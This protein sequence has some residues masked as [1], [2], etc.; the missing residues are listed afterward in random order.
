MIQRIPMKRFPPHCA[1][2]LL[3]LLGLVQGR[4]QEVESVVLTVSNADSTREGRIITFPV[5]LKSNGDVAGITFNLKYNQDF[6][7]RPLFEWSS[8]FG[9]SINSVNTDTPGKMAFTFAFP[10]LTVP[11]GDQLVGNLT[12]RVRSMPFGM[13]TLI[14]PELIE[15]SDAL[16]DP[17]AGDHEAKLGVA[18]ID[19]RRV[20]GD[21]NGN[22]Y[23]DVGDATLIQ[24]LVA[25]LDSVRSWDIGL[26]D[27]NK[28]GGLDSGDV[29]KVLRVVV[30]VD[31]QPEGNRRLA[32]M[33]G[34]DDDSDEKVV[35]SIVKMN[36]GV[37]TVQVA[38][39]DMTTNVSG[40]S[41]ELQFSN[42]V[43]RLKKGSTSSAGGGEFSFTGAVTYNTT[44]GMVSKES[45]SIW[46]AN[47]AGETPTKQI[48]TLAMAVTSPEPWKVK[49]GA[50][51]EVTFEVQEGA[52]INDAILSIKPV[53]VTPDGFDNRI[54]SGLSLNLGTGKTTE[55][56]TGDPVGVQIVEIINVPFGFSF[57]S[58]DGKS[59]V[60]EVTQDLKQWGEL[61]THEGTG[62]PV[63]FTDPRL[64]IVPFKRNFYR[65]RVE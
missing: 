56:V 12:L 22:G 35:L 47:Q 20:K 53:E 63:K 41:F 13:E 38:L 1:I 21:N 14:E 29:V 16:G 44:G 37:V 45:Q 40:A 33:G 28:S 60:V 65:V 10:G 34:G 42:E 9:L 11:A 2:L 25:G 3:C 49:D 6:L 54:I 59:Y 58:A 5:M 32:K 46:N 8:L 64:P 43:L 30:G 51:A 55:L 61:E 50:V 15:V 19:P 18:R 48:G 27:L 57:T 26:N 62:K 39:D 17:I 23:L 36:A 31:P 7:G 24:R 52:D 4:A